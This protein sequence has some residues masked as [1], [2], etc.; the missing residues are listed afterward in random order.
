MKD[1]VLQNTHHIVGK[2]QLATFCFLMLLIFFPA[3]L[4]AKT[5]HLEK[6]YQT[7][8]CDQTG[9]KMEVRLDD[10]T[11][12]DCL[13]EEFAIE[14]DF[15]KKWAESIGQALHYSV[16]TGRQGGIVLIL[17]HEKDIKYWNRLNNIIE[18]KHLNIKTWIMRP[19][20]L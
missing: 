14:F 9:G 6:A 5:L 11:R 3:P 7:K 1:T 2:S 12:V 18:K 10:A 17:E 20:D 15:G 19:E 13:T 8:W 4:E 16:K